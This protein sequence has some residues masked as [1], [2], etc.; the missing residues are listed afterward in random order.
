MKQNLKEL[1]QLLAVGATNEN[2]NKPQDK[3]LNEVERFY[4]SDKF[5]GSS[6]NIKSLGHTLPRRDIRPAKYAS[7]L[8]ELELSAV[9]ADQLELM[10]SNAIYGFRSKNIFVD[11]D[12][13]ERH[14]KMDKARVDPLLKIRPKTA[15]IHQAEL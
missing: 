6:M 8:Q 15:V 7:T 4:R 11:R 3:G 2:N 13:L 5:I 9:N 12:L 14:K 1:D 10:N